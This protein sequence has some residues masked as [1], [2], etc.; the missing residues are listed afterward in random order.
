MYV[1]ISYHVLEGYPKNF[2]KGTTFFLY[3]Q[4]CVLFFHN[5]LSR[6]YILSRARNFI[7][8]FFLHFS[9]PKICIYQKKVLPLHRIKEPNQINLQGGKDAEADSPRPCLF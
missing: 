5:I 8:E 9:N 3:T 4:A 2:C 1:S 6:S 7:Y